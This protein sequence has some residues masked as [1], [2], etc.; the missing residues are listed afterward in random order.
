[1]K[2]IKWIDRWKA[3]F[4]NL[5]FKTVFAKIKKTET[6]IKRADRLKKTLAF[7][8]FQ[9]IAISL[10]CIFG[11]AEL[12]PLTY[13]DTSRI[14]GKIE[15]FSHV[16]FNGYRINI[17]HYDLWING[18]KYRLAV[19]DSTCESMQEIIKSGASVEFCVH[20]RVFRNDIADFQFESMEIRSLNDYNTGNSPFRICA[21]VLFS[22]VEIFFC[23]AY[24]FY[25][26]LHRTS[27]DKRWI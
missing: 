13:E 7:L 6:N 11:I 1:M 12:K 25:I 20:D 5:L 23:T 10:F 27:R 8:L 2:K 26:L 19:N 22:L 4:D 21:I 3:Y 17:H 9:V 16:E 15:D 18:Q 14:T 24:A